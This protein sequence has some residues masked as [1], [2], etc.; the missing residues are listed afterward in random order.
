MSNRN[1]IQ[2]SVQLSQAN[3]KVVGTV[4]GQATQTYVFG[5]GGFKKLKS[6][7]VSEM[8]KNANLTGSQA[9]INTNIS[10]K[11]NSYVVAATKTAIAQGTIIEFIK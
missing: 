6:S 2:T 4:T 9:I 3:Y 1:Q 10:Y 5:I 7:A 11:T 8:Y